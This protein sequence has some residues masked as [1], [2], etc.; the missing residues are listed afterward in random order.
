[1]GLPAQLAGAGRRER[2]DRAEQF[3]GNLGLAHRIHHPP[4][5]L[6]GGEQQRV[7]IARALIND[8]PL[9]IADEPTDSLDSTSGYQV[10]HLLEDVAAATRLSDG[11]TVH[12]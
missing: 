11:R 8:P 2:R 10:I 1:M 5:D 9:I 4:S 12:L 7:A 6:S 3:L